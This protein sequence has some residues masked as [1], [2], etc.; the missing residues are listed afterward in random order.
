MPSTS[1]KLAQSLLVLKEIQDSGKIAIRAGDITRTHRERLLNSGF[2]QEVMKGW[3]IPMHPGEAPGDSTAWYASFWDF[4]A[5]YLRSRFGNAWCLSPEQSLAL[6]TGNW[7]VPQQLLVRTPKGGNKPT[8]LLYGTSIFDVRLKLP[9]TEDIEKLN[10][11]N[12]MSLAAALIACRPTHF[13][14][15]PLETRS[16]LAMLNEPSELLH[17]MLEGSH[18]KVAGRL[19][20]ALRNIGRD[21][22]ADTILQTMQAAGYTVYEVDPFTESSPILF[23]NRETSPYVNRLKMM[24]FGFRQDIIKHFP[25]TPGKSK[26]PNKIAHFLQ[27]MDHLYASDAYHSL[28]IEGYRVN[29]S[30]IERVQSGNWNPEKVK[31][32]KE[33]F[34]ALAARGYWQAFQAVKASIIDVLNGKDAGEATADDYQAWYR[35]LF[36][37]SVAA[38]I[39]SAT[40][41][42]GLRNRPV[43]IRQSM[44]TPPKSDAVRDLM[45]TFFELL[46]QEESAEVRIVLGHF[47]FVYIHPFID[48]NGRTARFLMNLMLT[49]GG[50]P[51]LVI[52][53]ERRNEYMQAL[54]SASVD[55]DIV[56]F[57]QFLARLLTAK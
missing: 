36:A 9:Q 53:V 8:H 31:E 29:A 40:D 26:S 49:A 19:A 6:Q 50:Y 4:C 10:G 15:A 43:Y 16:A 44:H 25:P 47:T 57:T 39:I 33:Q 56:P 14:A 12:I 35:E 42:A 46:Q 34:N 32:D 18:S 23:G 55:H 20:G 1:E 22:I 45:P 52:P 24:W 51:W 30:L 21:H 54:E 48:G 41:L 38:G 13:T 37:P 17:K 7:N 3:Y 11:L 2:I 28:S 27:Q 5:N